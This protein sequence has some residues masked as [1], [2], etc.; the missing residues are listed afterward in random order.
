MTYCHPRHSVL[1]VMPQTRS[2][3]AFSPYFSSVGVPLHAPADFMAHR[4]IEAALAMQEE[5][6][7]EERRT[8][9]GPEEDD[10]PVAPPDLHRLNSIDPPD[11][12]SPPLTPPAM[13]PPCPTATPSEP[14]LDNTPTKAALHRRAHKK[15]CR[16]ANRAR[17]QDPEMNRP[18]KSVARM[19]PSPPVGSTRPAPSPS[20][21]AQESTARLTAS[22]E[23]RCEASPQ[24]S[25]QGRVINLSGSATY[26]TAL[27]LDMDSA[28]VASS[29]YVGVQDKRGEDEEL[30]AERIEELMAQGYDYIVWDGR[31]VGTHFY[32]PT[33]QSARPPPRTSHALLDYTGT[34]VIGALAGSPS[35]P[36]YIE[37]ANQELQ[38]AFDEANATYRFPK[39]DNRRGPD[40]RAIS[41]GI[42]FGGGQQVSAIP[43]PTSITSEC[44][45]KTPYYH[46]SSSSRVSTLGSCHKAVLQTRPWS[47]SW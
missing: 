30:G 46:D 9:G 25:R 15:R 29:G 14:A 45:T 41:C 12:S 24:P 5:V 3:W 7:D 47:T 20:I 43:P 33:F 19:R 4:S 6:S 34:F 37:G 21:S 22:N 38:H 39:E 17:N 42:S 31:Y 16:N 10:R 44:A 18:V 8:W 1:K 2:G 40:V 35:D 13:S 11:P 27:S 28:P 23:S 32:A 36:T 26:T